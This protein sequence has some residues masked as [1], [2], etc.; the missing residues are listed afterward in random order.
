MLHEPHQHIGS[1]NPLFGAGSDN[2]GGGAPT[3]VDIYGPKIVVGNAL[4][5]DTLLVCNYLDAGDGVQLAIALAAASGFADGVDLQ[6]RPGTYTLTTTLTVPPSCVFRG[7][8]DGTIIISGATTRTALVFSDFSYGINFSVQ[9]STPALGAAGIRLIDLTE[10][11][12][13]HNVN[14][15]APSLSLAEQANESLTTFVECRNGNTVLGVR[16]LCLY[17]RSIDGSVGLVSCFRATEQQSTWLVNC[18]AQGADIGFDIS[19]RAELVAPAARGQG[20]TGILL[21]SVSTSSVAPT[22]LGGIVDL[23]AFPSLG[24]AADVRGVQLATGALAA[25]MF[26][27]RVHGTTIIGVNTVDAT[28]VGIELLGTGVGAVVEGCTVDQMPIGIAGSALQDYYNVI[29]NIV[30]TATTAY[31]LLGPNGNTAQ[32]VTVP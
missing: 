3:G 25:G 29:G 17:S 23:P 28:S 1:V 10:R 11:A 5:G 4:N 20:V 26:G 16:V 31:A 22:V 18:L 27:A 13:L 6:V 21:K 7:G 9:C 2:G 32:N 15:F 12:K 14:I 19:G 8:G 30:R 24:I